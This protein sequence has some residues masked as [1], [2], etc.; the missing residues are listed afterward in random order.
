MGE[1][2]RPQP[3]RAPPKR[4]LSDIPEPK[5]R[6]G[7]GGGIAN[8]V[9]SIVGA[10]IIGI[11]FSFRESGLVM[12][13]FLLVLVAYLTDKG[14][15]IIIEA[16]KFHPKLKMA[17]VQ[18][19]EDL[20]YLPF[21]YWGSVFVQANMFVLAYG[22]MVAYLLIIKDVVPAMF[23]IDNNSGFG[24]RELIMVCTSLVVM[25]PLALMRDMAS[26]SF[27]SSLSVTADF[28]LVIFVATFSPIGEALHENGGFWTVL[29][30]NVIN[31]R[32][33]IGLGIISTAMACQHSAFI[34]NG[35]LEEK[36]SAAWA[37]V[38]KYSLMIAL[39]MCALLGTMGFLGFLDETQ[40]N[41]LN[42]FSDGSVAAN[43]AR[44]LLSITMFFTYPME[45]LVARHVIAK[46]FYNGDYEGEITDENGNTH[47]PPKWF[48]LIGRRERIVLMLYVA[49]L[50]PALIV[51]DLGP[52]LSIT[53]SL[54]GSCV[55]YI[56]PG[57]I[58]L[59][60][61]G[62]S[63][64]EYTDVLLGKPPK[65][66]T[67]TAAELPVA[68]DANATMDAPSMEQGSKP[69]WWWLGL[70]PIW[71]AIASAGALGMRQNLE[72]LE[73]ESPGVTTVPPSGEVIGPITRDY[74]TAMF[75][76]I[77]GAVAVLVGLISNIYAIIDDTFFMPH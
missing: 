26:L 58:Y 64:I 5:T 3:R 41:V 56:G 48:G 29:G 77:F 60:V 19:Y 51:N 24:L 65:S 6:S 36:S 20:M 22:A 21:G 25:L 67:D 37:T 10:G 30:D 66:Q 63:F 55:A 45:C 39:T 59:G 52:V 43:G 53:G 71:R 14:L 68:G 46:M 62:E 40:G 49:T 34:V 4:T 38:T 61:H 16:A 69:F 42:N 44:G 76:I 17:G 1:P 72:Q 70:F 12:G 2:D 33:F 73:E 8:M 54:G 32:L 13:L 23:G 47:P 31:S 50:I 18:T 9:N 57:L 35:S 11:P 7:L 15:R 74:Y 28:C 27:T 75:F